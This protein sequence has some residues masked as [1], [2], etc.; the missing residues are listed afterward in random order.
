MDRPYFHGKIVTTI[1][2][3]RNELADTEKTTPCCHMFWNRKFSVELDKQYWLLPRLA[4]KETRLRLLQWKLFHNIYPTNIML[5]K[6]RVRE[7]QR[8]SYCPDQVDF[9]E[10]F[11]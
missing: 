7:N 3:F 2:G 10:H 8:C 1:K 9:I 6:M 4:T 11:L 5:C